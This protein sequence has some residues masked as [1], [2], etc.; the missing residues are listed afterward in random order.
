ML[1]SNPRGY[2][3]IERHRV[4]LPD[5]PVLELHRAARPETY[6]PGVLDGMRA[7][8]DIDGLARYPDVGSFVRRLSDFVGAPEDSI[9]VT[10]GIDGAI[11]EV[12]ETFT[13]GDMTKVAILTPTYKMYDVYTSA[14]GVRTR[15]VQTGPDLSIDPAEVF[16][17]IAGCDVVFVPN[18]HEP[19]ENVFSGSQ[20]IEFAGVAADAG[21][22]LVVDEAYF[23]FGAPTVIDSAPL[24][25]NLIVMRNFSKAIGLP[26]IRI[27][28]MVG[29]GDTMRLINSR[30]QAYETNSLSIGAA[31]WAMDNF[32]LF[33]R[34]IDSVVASRA[35]LKSEL[36]PLGFR[37]HGSVSNTVLIDIGSP[38]SA[39][40]VHSLLMDMGIWTRSLVGVGV[41][42]SWI[43]VTVGTSDTVRK[44]L[45]SFCVA[46]GEVERG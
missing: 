44:F 27:G 14:Y 9:A 40:K 32:G 26:G 4:P 10:S 7:S 15:R 36:A 17:A 21:T 5:F 23:M 42:E 39:L 16:D 12:M 25:R 13:S 35:L 2:C 46:V 31:T 43:S 19:I 1:P 22:L 24:S 20:M 45:D 3:P 8:L 11:R 30:R 29:H 38:K 28:Y 41:A 34:Y 6:A 37:T 33:E 18:P